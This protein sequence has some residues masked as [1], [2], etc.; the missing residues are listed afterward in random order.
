MIELKKNFC[1]KNQSVASE[2]GISENNQAR[3]Q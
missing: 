3:K 2:T 1:H